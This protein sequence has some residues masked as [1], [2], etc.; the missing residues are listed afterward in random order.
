MSLIPK[1]I[2]IF[3]ALYRCHFIHLLLD[4]PFSSASDGLRISG[5]G[6]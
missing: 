2:S 4:G 1:S 6:H 3:H 5:S